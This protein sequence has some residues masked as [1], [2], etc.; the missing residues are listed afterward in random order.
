MRFFKFGFIAIVTG[1]L[2][3]ILMAFRIPGAPA[4]QPCSDAWF[5]DIEAHY[6]STERENS[7]GDRIGLD[8]AAGDGS[9]W[10]DY[11]EA[12]A[13]A[14]HPPLGTDKDARCRLIQD[15]LASRT[16]IINDLTGWV[17]SFVRR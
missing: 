15:R 8:Y 11:I 6:F 17:L 10:F 1:A 2:L 9:A 16:Y 3:L 7:F 12:K 14:Q 5:N 4:S 13:G